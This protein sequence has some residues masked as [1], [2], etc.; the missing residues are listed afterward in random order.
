MY[1]IFGGMIIETTKQNIHSSGNIQSTSCTI[2]AQDMRYIASLLRNNYSDTILATMREIV[3]NGIDVSS[4]KKVDVQLPTTIEPNFIVRDYGYGLSEEDM[5]GLYTKYGKSTKRDS[6][7]AIGGFGIG[8]FAPL[9]Y[10]DSFI[11]MSVCD[12]QKTAYTIRVDENDDTV[13]SKMY[14]ESSDEKN[15]VYVQVP[16]KNEN[17]ADFNSKFSNFSQYLT[18]KINLLNQKWNQQS[19]SF[20]CDVFDFYPKERYNYRNC[21]ELFDKAHIL[22]GGILYPVKTSDKYPHFV[23]GVVYKAEIGEVKLHHSRESLEYN[24]KTVATLVAASEKIK[25]SFQKSADEKLKNAKCLYK[26]TEIFNNEIKTA[27]YLILGHRTKH[28]VTWR[29]HKLTGDLFEVSHRA[30]QQV[31]KIA[32]GA[33]SVKKVRNMYSFHGEPHEK[34]HFIID[35]GAT[36]RAIKNRLSWINV[37]SQIYVIQP[38]DAIMERFNAMKSENVTLLSSHERTVAPRKK[39]SSQGSSVKKGD[40]MLFEQQNAWN[41]SDHAFWQETDEEFSDNE[42]YYYCTYYANKVQSKNGLNQSARM[43]NKDLFA[44]RKINPKLGKVYGV[45]KKDLKKIEKKSNWIHIDDV[46][47]GW[48]DNSQSLKEAK[49]FF[50]LNRLISEYNKPS[51][52]KILE[53]TASNEI[54]LNFLNLCKETNSIKNTNTWGIDLDEIKVDTSKERKI[55]EDFL[56]AYP[57]VAHVIENFRYNSTCEKL[58]EDLVNYLSKW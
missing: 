37:D 51:I 34:R 26:A 56:A 57:M 50:V 29:G 13:V 40:I 2:D 8:R 38:T 3:A 35:D 47:Q 43:F 16:I 55:Q 22:M 1:A 52:M 46:R 28:S 36:P 30:I 24:D 27:A 45:R 18:D 39:Q 58:R 49:K 9:S 14:S 17:I 5:L 7:N 33:V 19:P 11:V 31:N 41:S 20:S 25:A 12:G 23:R 4:G 54:I 10:T 21:S 53:E 44:L 15:G 42:V 6:N 32:N 48:I